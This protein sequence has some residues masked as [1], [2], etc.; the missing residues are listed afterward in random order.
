VKSRRS[1]ALVVEDDPDLR[2]LLATILEAEDLDVESAE[3][4][5]QALESM[6]RR[7]PDLILLDMRM[8]VMDGWAFCRELDRRGP[9]PPIVVLTAA[10]DPAERAAEVRADGWLGKPFDYRSLRAQL[11]R[12]LPAHDR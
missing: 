11:D 12:F 7:R 8:P 5:R 10:T 3:N 2:E 1:I 6:E 4:G 9:R